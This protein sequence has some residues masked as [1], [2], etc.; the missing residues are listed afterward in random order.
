MNRYEIE[1]GL[2]ERTMDVKDVP[3]IWNDKMQSYLGNT[4]NTLTIYTIIF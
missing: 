3:T 1:K 2:I 4:L